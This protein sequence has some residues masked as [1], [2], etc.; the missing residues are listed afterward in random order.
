MLNTDQTLAL[1]Q[2]NDW[3]FQSNQAFMIID[4]SGGVGKTYLLSAILA[5]INPK[6]P[7]LL[8]PTNEAVY[9]IRQK[10][11]HYSNV[12]Y[13]TIH[14][15]LGIAPTVKESELRFEQLTLP[16]IWDNVDFVAVDES[17]MISKDILKLLIKLKVKILFLGHKAQLPPVN[18]KRLSTDLCISPVFEKDWPTT[19]LTI[20]MR[21]SSTSLWKFL[22]ELENNIY[23]HN[24]LIRPDY[25][26]YKKEIKSYINSP[27]GEIDL[28]SGNLKFI[29]W[30]NDGVDSY[31]SKLR[32]RLFGDQS[33]DTLYIKDDLIILVNPTTVIPDL[34]KL[35]ERILTTIQNNPQLQILYTNTKA[36]VI[37]AKVVKFV[38]NKYITL[39][40]YELD[41]MVEKTPLTIYS[42]VDKNDSK[43]LNDY[44]E[45]LARNTKDY[46]R[47]K[48]IY[49]FKH[50]LNSCFAQIKHSYAM[51]AHRSQGSSIDRVIVVDH[52]IMRN[53]N[54]IEAAKCR[55][56]GCSRTVQDY[57]VLYRGY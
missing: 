45:N 34:P 29:L 44:Y 12:I 40:L 57:P 47:K 16:A 8:A 13:K 22:C 21:N 5:K 27:Q 48:R 37:T 19:T 26:I 24:K 36:V 52:D 54:P 23:S 14:S 3:F 7:L 2:V 11:S 10:T 56:V 4:G 32:Q 39:N 6:N 49:K 35:N 50:F 43:V 33:K 30:S 20:P 31:N 51:T 41:I 1:A 38:L 53:S 55:Y 9:Q 17:S 46:N 25:V 15:A 42:L 18:V 28:M